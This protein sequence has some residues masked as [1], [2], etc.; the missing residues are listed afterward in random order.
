MSKVAIDNVV[1]FAET[2]YKSFKEQL[3]KQTDEDRIAD[4][5]QEYLT[6][7][8]QAEDELEQAAETKKKGKGKKQTDEVQLKP[9]S[10][11]SVNVIIQQTVHAICL[12][13]LMTQLGDIQ[14]SCRY[15]DPKTNN[16]LFTRLNDVIMLLSTYTDSVRDNLK[17]N[18]YVDYQNKKTTHDLFDYL[19]KLS[20]IGVVST[21]KNTYTLV[22]VST[23]K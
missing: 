3:L 8:P 16:D 23:S 19:N 2:T 9:Y 22:E 14:K 7:K 12:Y 20:D 17:Y 11:D 18:L 10:V 6:K 15:V 21:S 4:Y 13:K 1:K 5:I